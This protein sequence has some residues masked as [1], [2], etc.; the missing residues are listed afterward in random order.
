MV[1][2]SSSSTPLK[3]HWACWLM[4]LCETPGRV[5]HELG[6]QLPEFRIR[7]LW[8]MQTRIAWQNFHRRCERSERYCLRPLFFFRPTERCSGNCLTLK[9]SKLTKR[10]SCVIRDIYVKFGSP[11]IST[12]GCHFASPWLDFRICFL[13]VVLPSRERS[14]Y[15][16]LGKGQSSSNC[17]RYL[18]EWI[19]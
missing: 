1:V 2:H 10:G 3:D 12:P 13:N 8:T 5:F 16:T 17:Q 15:P 11:W 6:F 19:C 9:S 4:Y 18:W 14:S 7:A